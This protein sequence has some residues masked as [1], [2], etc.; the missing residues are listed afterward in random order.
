MNMKN[1]SE[2]RGISIGFDCH[3]SF[4]PPRLPLPSNNGLSRNLLAYFVT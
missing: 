2:M 3:M 1:D 4:L